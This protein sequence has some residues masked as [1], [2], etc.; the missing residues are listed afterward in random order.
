V[1][2][3]LSRTFR[4]GVAYASAGHSMTPGNGLFLTSSN[5]NAGAGYSYTGLRYWSF[6][7]QAGWDRAKSLGNVLGYYGNTSGGLS[8]S[9]DIG[10][11][12]HA[13]ASFSARQY[14]SPDFSKYNR[15]IY[16]A[17]IALGFTPGDIPLRVW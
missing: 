3:R 1:G 6:N 5:T 4:R 7:M 8:V 9:R 10:H 15:L 17:R 14:Q 13:V 12:L 11:G 2:A 16:T